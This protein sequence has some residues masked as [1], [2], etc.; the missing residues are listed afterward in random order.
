MR[1]A[2]A[3]LICTSLL[4]AASAQ[5]A[6]PKPASHASGTGAVASSVSQIKIP[7]LHPFH[8]QQPKRIQL[9]NGMIIF[10]QEDH[11]LPLV[12]ATARIR[13]GA[14]DIP[15]AKAGMMSVYG[16]SWRTGG[17]KSQTGDQLDDFL[18]ARA[19][20]VETGGGA[21]ST[22]ISFS[23]LKG[24]LNDVFKV[25]VDVLRDPEF[26]QDKVDLAKRQL[27]TNISRR[28][29]DIDEIAGREARK[30]GYGP[31]NPYARVPEYWTVSA[32]TRDDL[33][34]WHKAHVHPNNIILGVVGDFDSTEMERKL[35]AAFNS[36]PKG[37]AVLPTQIEFK[38]PAPTVYFA[39]KEDVNQ[40]AIQ[41]ITLG[42]TRKNPDYFAISV[43]NELFGGGFSSRLFSNIRSRK[44][45]AYS[46]GGG[47]GTDFDHPGLFR[48][49]VGTKSA[50]TAVA[51]TALQTEIA[52]LIKNPGTPEEV[53]RAK[54]N[55]LSGFVFEFDS[56]EK[57]LN[58]RMAY[59]YYGYPPD[60]IEQYRAGVEK[61]TPGDIAR[62]VQ[63]YVAGK[64]FATLVVGN[65]KDF[66]KPLSTFGKVTQL[67]ISIKDAPD[68]N[69]AVRA[70]SSAGSAP[71]ASN[72]EGKALIAKVASGMGG[73]DKLQTVKA[74]A[75]KSDQTRKGPQGDMQTEIE[76][77][78]VYPDRTAA[79]MHTPFGEVRVVISPEASFMSL[80]GQCGK[81][82]CAICAVTRCSWRSMP[83]ILSTH[84][85]R[86]ASRK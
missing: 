67:D 78:S 15:A 71:T 49:V 27:S 53:Q 13:G 72:A 21:D 81:T 46:V 25:F 3:L 70:D 28:N 12:D 22:N 44:G 7:P 9:E 59:E 14:R 83:M 48:L 69:S 18:E 80:P 10:L 61:V 34:A 65:D 84:S 62:V 68:A 79:T 55:I 38:A 39:P 19:A 57:I 56:K 43:M 35:R 31:D 8:P 52:D 20:K 33:L 30:I 6:A 54:D 74:I 1:S 45:L 63:K 73:L 86:T 11:E 50:T 2:L 4:S 47:I 51:I 40:S 64:Q 76:Q 75:S 77:V 17:T 60:F 16:Q 29:D 5:T 24:D 58:E 32:I 66:D 82:H 36:W 41:L 26:R 37:P 42:T 85:R 23:A